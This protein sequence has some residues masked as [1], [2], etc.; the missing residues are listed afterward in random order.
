[1]RLLKLARLCNPVRL[2]EVAPSPEQ[3][4]EL[5]QFKLVSSKESPNLLQCLKDEL[6]GLRAL[7]ND[8]NA[9][10][11]DMESILPFFSKSQCRTSYLGTIRISVGFPTDKLSKCRKSVLNVETGMKGNPRKFA[12]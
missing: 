1:M 7:A 6:P 3:S 10:L 5:P 2:R 12:K 8:I 4:D 9:N 11:F